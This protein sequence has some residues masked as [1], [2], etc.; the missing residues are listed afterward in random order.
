MTIDGVTIC[1]QR[2]SQGKC[3]EEKY[4]RGTQKEHN[5]FFTHIVCITHKF[6]WGP[7][8][9]CLYVNCQLMILRN[10]ISEIGT[11]WNTYLHHKC[12]EIYWQF[13]AFDSVLKT[14]HTLSTT[15]SCRLQFEI[16]SLQNPLCPLIRLIRKQYLSAVPIFDLVSLRFPAGMLS[17]VSTRLLCRLEGK[18]TLIGKCAD[19]LKMLPFYYS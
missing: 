18:C 13:A 5:N 14:Q 9:I 7:I 2:D 8:T 3:S 19:A 11:E 10:I 12:A 17:A 1:D 6:Y 16:W 4:Y 15:N